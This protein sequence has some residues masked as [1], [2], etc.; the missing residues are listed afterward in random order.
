VLPGAWVSGGRGRAVS[1]GR[2]G[3]RETRI[4]V[5]GRGCWGGGGCSGCESHAI[6]GCGGPGRAGGRLWAA[7]G[8]P[9]VGG[10]GWVLRW[11]CGAGGDSQRRRV[12]VLFGAVASVVRLG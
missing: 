8:G 1:L 11:G 5:R 12:G 10:R 2:H 9:A 6:G 4:G 3:G 7:E